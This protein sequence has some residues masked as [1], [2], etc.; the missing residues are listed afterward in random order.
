MNGSWKEMPRVSSI[1]VEKIE[2]EEDKQ[3]KKK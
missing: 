2:E 1:F 3:K